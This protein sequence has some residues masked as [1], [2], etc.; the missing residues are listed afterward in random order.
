M[1]CVD[2]DLPLDL[3]HDLP[4]LEDLTD[5]PGMRVALYGR[6]SQDPEHDEKGVKRQI[7]LGRQ[8]VK[9][10]GGIV[11][12]ERIDNDISALKGAPRPGYNDIMA[13]AKSGKITHI[14]VQHTSRWWRNRIERAIGIGELQAARVGLI[15][16]KGTELD[17]TSASGRMMAGV[18]GEFDT[19]ESE[20]KSERILAKVEELA[21]EGK[22]ANGGPRPFGFTRIYV[23]E[24]PRRKIIRDEINEEEAEVIRDC[25]R[26]ILAGEPARSVATDLNARGV[27]T[28]TGARWSVQSLTWMLQSGRVA[29]LRERHRK[30]VAKAVWPAIIDM[31]THQ[32]LRAM[33][34]GRRLTGGNPRKHYPSGYVFCSNPDCLALNVKMKAFRT[35]KGIAKY[36]CP[37]KAD[38]G[39]GGRSI[40]LDA[41]LEILDTYMIRRLSDPQTL[42]ELAQ[43]ENVRTAESDRLLTQID[44]DQR[45]LNL[46]QATLT[47]GDEQDIPEVIASMRAIRRRI[48]EA[49]GRLAGVA[50][51]PE[52]EGED[53]PDLAKRWPDLPVMRKAGLLAAFVERI[54]VGPGVRGLGRVDPRRVQ[55]VPRQTA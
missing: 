41:L 34:G 19:A 23:G 2:D 7:K 24:G 29:G 11:V 17:F 55:I 4:H 16:I 5:V 36:R 9:Q 40:D 14:V 26:R 49:R 52:L 50:K 47:D 33:F 37:P 45:R 3:L 48:T 10:R 13:A 51:V 35:I 15:P 31:E 21:A 8:L 53:L 25:A 46:L 27:A 18:I 39:C 12:M 30:V 38:G 54:V 6:I 22:I 1:R 43:R 20:F 44:D 42:R 32:Q 28:S